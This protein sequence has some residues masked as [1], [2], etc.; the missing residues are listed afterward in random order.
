MFLAAS[1]CRGAA[2]FLAVDRSALSSIAFYAD[3]ATDKNGQGH[4][5]GACQY[6]PTLFAFATAT[7]AA[8]DGDDTARCMP[9]NAGH[10]C[11]NSKGGKHS[12][13]D[14]GTDV[15]DYNNPSDRAVDLVLSHGFKI[16]KARKYTNAPVS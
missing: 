7:R 6:W 3:Q 11:P 8:Y 4:H 16:N 1:F 2:H 13:F 10:S 12:P 5:A 15:L 14:V 9:R